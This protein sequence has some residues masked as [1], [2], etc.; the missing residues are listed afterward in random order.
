VPP[1]SRRARRPPARRRPRRPGAVSP[2]PKRSWPRR[3]LKGIGALLIVALVAGAAVLGARQVWFVGTDSSEERALFRGLP[4]ELPFGIELYSE[5]ESS[6]VPL[7]SLPVDGPEVA[8]NHELR[9]QDDARSLLEDLEN[10]AVTTT[11]DDRGGNGGGGAGGNKAG[12]GGGG[13]SG[14]GGSPSGGGNG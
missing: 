14:G 13:S 4:Y 12:G 8:T 11:V 7:Q 9:S 5:Q 6:G 3:V 2:A 10:T 1:V